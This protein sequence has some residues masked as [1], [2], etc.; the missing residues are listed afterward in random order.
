MVY[1]WIEAARGRHTEPRQ[2]MRALCVCVLLLQAAPL[3]S[4]PPTQ[5][6]A[7]SPGPGTAELAAGGGHVLVHESSGGVTVWRNLQGVPRAPGQ[8]TK[9]LTKHIDLSFWAL[10][11]LTEDWHPV[12]N[13]FTNFSNVTLTLDGV[14]EGVVPLSDEV[15]ADMLPFMADL[16][17]GV[18]LVGSV[19]VLKRAGSIWHDEIITTVIPGHVLLVTQVCHWGWQTTGNYLDVILQVQIPPEYKVTDRDRGA[20]RP[21]RFILGVTDDPGYAYVDIAN[22]VSVGAEVK[23]HT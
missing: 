10:D 8:D 15:E 11:E 13:A 14:T 17:G 19:S 18:S 21:T 12:G 6:P 9:H 3:A 4:Q 16:G 20:S 2:T 7:A 23:T 22:V 5:H 1:V